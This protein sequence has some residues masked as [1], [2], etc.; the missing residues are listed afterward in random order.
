MAVDQQ[1]YQLTTLALTAG[2]WDV[3]GWMLVQGIIGSEWH[4]LSGTITNQPLGMPVTAGNYVSLP[5]Q[6]IDEMP[7]A[8][9]MSRVR[10]SLAAP[11]NV[12]LNVRVAAPENI[13]ITGHLHAR[14][15]R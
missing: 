9:S 8:I 10:F 7:L 11:G 2:D 12:Y 13:Q 6:T 1:V 15:V 3:E 4:G 14:R 5:P